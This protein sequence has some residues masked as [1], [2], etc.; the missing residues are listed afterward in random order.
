MATTDAAT[1]LGL[2]GEIGS[3]VPGKKAD[4]VILDEAPLHA[5]PCPDLL[6]AL[7]Y[8]YRAQD[9]FSVMVD[10]RFVYHQRVFP[11]LDADDVLAQARGEA[12]GLLDRAG[13]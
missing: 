5:T 4:L 7:V 3:I 1:A 13:L 12:Q 9:V 11:E 2:E 10:G 6:N 8:A